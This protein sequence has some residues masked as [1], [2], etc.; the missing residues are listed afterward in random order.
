MEKMWHFTVPEP[1]VFLSI[2]S[3]TPSCVLTRR[4]PLPC[5]LVSAIDRRSIKRPNLLPVRYLVR[6]MLALPPLFGLKNRLASRH[7]SIPVMPSLLTLFGEPLTVTLT[8]VMSG[9]R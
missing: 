2:A 5:I 4:W 7:M 3:C 6:F 1:V 8:L 9:L